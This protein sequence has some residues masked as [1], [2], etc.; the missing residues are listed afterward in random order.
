M[1]LQKPVYKWYAIYTKANN[2]KKVFDRLKEEN[3]ECYL[4]LKKTL[5]QWSDRKKWVDLPLFRCYVFVKVSYIEYFR[6]LRIPGVVYYVSFGG[7]PQSIPNN[8]IEYI[9]AIVQQ[10]EKEIEV[11]YKNIRKG[12]ECEVLVGPLKGIKGEVVRISGQ[13]RLLIRL[14]S[15]GVSLNVNISKDEIKLIKNKATRTAQKKYSSL[16]RIPYKKSGASVY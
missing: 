3:I 9:K 2:E 13:S 16:D 8:Q 1:Y 5:R 7:E 14:A 10:T 12:S 4:P 11:N 6:A 15:M